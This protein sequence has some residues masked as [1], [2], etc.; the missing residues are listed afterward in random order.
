MDTFIKIPII[1]NKKTFLS[2]LL[3]LIFLILVSLLF[4]N[5]IIFNCAPFTIGLI[6]LIYIVGII[7][8]FNKSHYVYGHVILSYEQIIVE[9]ENIKKI[10]PLSDIYNLKFKYFGSE[11]DSDI[12]DFKTFITKDGTSNFLNFEYENKK[13][14]FELLLKRN[15]I[16]LLRKI[17]KKWS[18]IKFDIKITGIKL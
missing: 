9:N 1:K 6:I 13:Y 15:Y 18:E 10:F 5:V 12:S 17:L 4:I 2:K 16:N 14:S 7:M 11:G 3:L 8:N